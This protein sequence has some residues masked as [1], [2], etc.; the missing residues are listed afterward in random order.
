MYDHE[1]DGFEQ[2][3]KELGLA[4][5]A[6]TINLNLPQGET[7]VVNGTRINPSVITISKTA[8]SNPKRDARMLAVMLSTS[9]DEATLLHLSEFLFAEHLAPIMREQ[10]ER[11]QKI[12]AYQKDATS[13]DEARK[14]LRK[15]KENPEE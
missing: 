5:E 14:K 4:P 11:F 9:L 7:L 8:E 10:A 3:A 2:F 1:D 6:P 13:I 12:D 15:K